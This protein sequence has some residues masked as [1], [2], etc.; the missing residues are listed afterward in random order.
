[1]AIQL[2]FARRPQHTLPSPH[3]HLQK[4]ITTELNYLEDFLRLNANYLSKKLKRQLNS[5]LALA[6]RPHVNHFA[7]LLSAF[8]SCAL[9]LLTTWFS[10]LR[11]L[12]QLFGQL[13]T[14]IDA[15]AG[16]LEELVNFCGTT[17]Q[18]A[19]WRA[20]LHMPGLSLG[21]AAAVR[22]LAGKLD[23]QKACPHFWPQN[24]VSE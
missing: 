11:S 10:L 21:S 24:P 17:A 2:R 5:Q 12:S 14:E 6:L 4:S 23:A 1:M 3:P 9:T 7:I 16:K 13:L 18:R 20:D 22:M 8:D 15:V 19:R